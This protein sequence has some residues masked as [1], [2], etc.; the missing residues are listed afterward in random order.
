MP[1]KKKDA[2]VCTPTGPDSRWV[3]GWP[4]RVAK[5]GSVM[6]GTAA[7]G[8]F[9]RWSF[10]LT[11]YKSIDLESDEDRDHCVRLEIQ[12]RGKG[13]GPGK[14]HSGRRF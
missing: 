6:V 9:K 3:D 10:K 1:K 12:H 13:P 8:Q 4:Y 7:S 14:R 5:S 11:S 2:D